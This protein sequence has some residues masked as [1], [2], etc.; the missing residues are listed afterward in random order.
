[1]RFACCKQLEVIDAAVEKLV[2]AFGTDA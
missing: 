2:S 1:V